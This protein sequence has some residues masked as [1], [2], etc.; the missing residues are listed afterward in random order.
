M[1]AF[2]TLYVCMTAVAT[3]GLLFIVLL[4]CPYAILGLYHEDKEY[5]A[6]SPEGTKRGLGIDCAILSCQAYPSQII[7]ASTI[8]AIIKAAGTVRVVS[9]FAAFFALL[10][11]LTA[12]F[13]IHYPSIKVNEDDVDDQASCEYGDLGNDEHDRIGGMDERRNE[14]NE[15]GAAMA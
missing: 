5:I 6:H 1:T 8:S 9:A 12:A 15:S 14:K 13:L 3:M 7:V 10:A 4:Y 2:P 11:F